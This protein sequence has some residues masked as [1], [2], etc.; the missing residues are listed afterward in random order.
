MTPTERY[1]ARVRDML[2]RLDTDAERRVFLRSQLD[3][4]EE[5]YQR[6]MDTEGRSAPGANAADFVCT[7]ADLQ[8]EIAKHERAAA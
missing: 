3:T 2:A 1:M 4:W 6:F 8:S 5:R 7:I